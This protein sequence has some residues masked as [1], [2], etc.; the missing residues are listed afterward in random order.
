MP[1][2]SG[3]RS[4]CR[5]S[6]V[7]PSVLTTCRTDGHLFKEAQDSTDQFNRGILIVRMACSTPH[8]A[9]SPS[10]VTAQKWQL[11]LNL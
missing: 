7:T 10:I 9:E 6:S 8:L 3:L 5:A 11:L 1:Q 4:I 2:W